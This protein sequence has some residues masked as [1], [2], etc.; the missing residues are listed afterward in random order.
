MQNI[1]FKEI[2]Y[3]IFCQYNIIH[4]YSPVSPV[5]SLCDRDL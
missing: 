2:V 1:G 4:S 3:L 5:S